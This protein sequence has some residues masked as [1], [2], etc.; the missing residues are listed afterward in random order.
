[1]N[2]RNKKYALALLGLLVV[3][4]FTAPNFAH[5]GFM[6]RTL[7]DVVSYSV[8][9][10]LYIFNFLFS[11]LFGLAGSLVAFTLKLNL[12]V[13]NTAQNALI[14]VGWTI[15]RD[16]ANLGFV[17]AMIIIAF[18]TIVRSDQY[19]YKKLL[20]RLIGAA[21]LVNFSL[22]IAGVFIDFSHVLTTFFLSKVSDAG[23]LGITEKLADAFGAQRYLLGESDNPLP[24]NPADE[25]GIGTKLSTA[26]V[27]SI[28]EIGFITAFTAIGAII[29][30]V[31]AIMLLI[32]FITLSF[33]M[34][35][36]PITW[37]FWVIPGQGKLF[38]Q[39]WDSFI[40]QVFFA[41][42]VTF[43]IYL[44]LASVSKLG[45]VNETSAFFK[46]GAL[47]AIL[48]AGSQMLVLVGILIGGMIAA[49]KMG[50]AGAKAGMDR[51]KGVGAAAKNYA[52]NRAQ[53]LGQRMAKSDTGKALARAGLRFGKG[54]RELG[55]KRPQS[56]LGKAAAIA[57]TPL[58]APV[59]FALEGVGKAAEKVSE[60][61]QKTATKAEKSPMKPLS[62]GASM[63]AGIV[64]G[65][66]GVEGYKKSVED[67]EK[68][69]REKEEK[70]AAKAERLDE[71][72]AAALRIDE[73]KKKK[74]AEERAAQ[75][76]AEAEE[77]SRKTRESLAEGVS[78]YKP[79]DTIRAEASESK[80]KIII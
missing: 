30:F 19:G 7:S 4:G 44:A 76:A 32:R 75:E 13:T 22:A 36:A 64:G 52:S 6:D 54:A 47:Q 72:V 23:Y 63:W 60:G 26:V 9:F 65:E 56:R 18:A 73:E 10:A 45:Q 14:G 11:I 25:A 40:K 16:I 28:A 34:I 48:V 49:E 80:P 68:K 17:L 50:I 78:E 35:L 20:P 29:L 67:V 42:T 61:A 66:K 77:R 31:L 38:S 58:R 51:I 59:Q 37:L 5:A 62:I 2:I 43:F 24:P 39:W 15:T 69:K 71:R 41:P 33:L 12:T 27:T 1:M 70:D 8:K 79:V 21:I 53:I 3:V 46:Q 55:E 74:T 57:T